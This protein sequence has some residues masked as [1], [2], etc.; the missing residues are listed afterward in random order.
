MGIWE[1]KITEI[2][3]PPGKQ[4][5]QSNSP[6]VRKMAGSHFSHLTV[7]YEE[8]ESQKKL[9]V[10]ILCPQKV[11]CYL[12]STYG[13]FLGGKIPFGWGKC[14]CSGVYCRLLHGV[15]IKKLSS[16]F[17][18]AWLC[19]FS[20]AQGRRYLV[21]TKCCA[22]Q[23]LQYHL[24]SHIQLLQNTGT[25]GLYTLTTQTNMYM[26]HALNLTQRSYTAYHFRKPAFPTSAL[27][28]HRISWS[29]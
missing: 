13:Q 27:I 10:I 2:Q 25:H 22:A 3:S 20:M 29:I 24:T 23:M 11:S 17:P 26:Y 21:Y 8:L 15:L 18:W 6:R 28:P 14:A 4:Q 16:E 19:K 9:L 1:H 12:M 5:L 7:L